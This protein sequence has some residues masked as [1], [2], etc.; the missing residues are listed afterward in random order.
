M[1]L[2][3]R[4]NAGEFTG[5]TISQYVSREKAREDHDR[6]NKLFRAA[7]R[8]EFGYGLS[9]KT[10]AKIESKSREDAKGEGFY[11]WANHYEELADFAREVLA[12]N[13]REPVET[14]PNFGVLHNR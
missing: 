7:L 11:G 10:I 2:H 9:E 6:L 13:K 8:E 1:D 12:D 4:I 14:N 5:K 3:D